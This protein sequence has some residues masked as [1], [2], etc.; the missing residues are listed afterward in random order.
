MPSAA[1]PIELVKALRQRVP[2]AAM[3]Q[4]KEALMA[5]NLDLDA[6]QRWLEGRSASPSPVQSA[7]ATPSALPPT[8]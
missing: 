1:V 6:A 7:E 2:G 5:A 3:K 4:C 8:K